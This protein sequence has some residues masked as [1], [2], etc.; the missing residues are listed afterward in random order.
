VIRSEKKLRE[1]SVTLKKKNSLLISETVKLLRDEDPLE[2]AVGLLA[3][4]YD[5][6]NEKPVNVS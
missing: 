6:T 1:L 5:E 3:S 2:G 4:F